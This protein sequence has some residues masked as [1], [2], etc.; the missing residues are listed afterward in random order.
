MAGS[1]ADP[2]ADRSLSAARGAGGGRWRVLYDA[3]CGLCT[4]L[5]AIILR[6]DRVEQLETVALQR[7]EA[8]DLL[9]D[10]TPAERMASWHLL[11]PDGERF[12]A[13]EALGPLLRELP[14]GRLPAAVLARFPGLVNRSYR[15]VAD[16][17]TRLSRWVPASAKR[18]AADLVREREELF[19]PRAC[20]RSRAAPGSPRRPT[21]R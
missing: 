7:P 2:G 21:P 16:H 20:R 1:H 15:W 10:L 5:L 13:G 8:A 11:S 6:R 9:A 12:S 4:W 19:S 18:R 14:R 17:R 3:D